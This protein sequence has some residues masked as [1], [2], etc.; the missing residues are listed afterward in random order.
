M[1]PGA[2]QLDTSHLDKLIHLLASRGYCVIGP[3]VRDHAI[4]FDEIGG[5]EDL[6]R[7]ITATSNPARYRLASEDS[8][9]LFHYW[10]GPDTLKKFLHPGHVR[11]VAAE[12]SNGAFRILDGAAN[13]ERRKPFAFL[14]IRPCDLAALRILDRVLLEDRFVDDE[15]RNRRTG[16]ILIPVNC[17]EPAPTCFCESLGAGPFARQG[18]DIS[19]T[20]T[21]SAGLHT[22]IAQPGSETGLELLK[23]LNAAPAD[24]ARH[25]AAPQTRSVDVEAAREIADSLFEHPRWEQTAARCLACGNCTQVCPTCFCVDVS[26]WSDVTSTRAERWR[27]WDS[28]FTQSFSYIHGGSV[29]LSPKSRY[30]H[31]WN[32]KLTRWQEQFGM[33][34]CVG[35]GRCITWCPAGIDITEEFAALTGA[36][37]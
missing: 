1:S 9:A 33:P 16:C 8:P 24:P 19:I 14:G 23:E 6:P 18:F 2:Y 21:V 36:A 4:T 12:K 30:R 28:C 27:T 15:Y 29:R 11:L 26:D 32:H 37:Q 7:G 35:C 5:I 22:L 31:W 20:E 17:A 10:T 3:V 25:S 34:G 13:P